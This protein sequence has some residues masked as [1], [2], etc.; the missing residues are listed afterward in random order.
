MYG[1]HMSLH[2]CEHECGGSGLMLS[3]SLDQS[4]PYI[5]RHSLLLKSELA[6]CLVWLAIL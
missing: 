4:P 5:L 2:V 3:A 1:L 6:V